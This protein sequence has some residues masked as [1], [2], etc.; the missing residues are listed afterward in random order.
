MMDANKKKETWSIDTISAEIWKVFDILKE[1]ISTEEFHVLLY[2]LSIYKDDFLHKV[3]MHNGLLK[4]TKLRMTPGIADPYEEI[5]KIYAPIYAKLTND[6]LNR[7]FDIVESIGK[8]VLVNNFHSIFDYILYKISDVLGKGDARIL[9]PMELTRLIQKIADL[10][11]EASVYNPFAG[12]ASFGVFLK[13]GQRYYGQELN[14]T[15]WAIGT[16]RILAHKRDENSIFVSGDSTENW[17]PNKEKYDLIIANPPFGIQKGYEFSTRIGKVRS[18]EA[19]FIQNGV[20]SLKDN[21]KLIAIVSQSFLNNSSNRSLITNSESLIRKYLVENDILETV[22]SF[23]GG[24]LANTAIPIAIIVINKEK[25]EKGKVRLIDAKSFIDISPNKEIKLNNNLFSCLTNNQNDK[26]N[27]RIVSNNTISQS[28]YN[29]RI[30]RYLHKEYDGIF[31]DKFVE[32]TKGIRVVEGQF[33]KF[34]RIRDLKVDEIYFNLDID[35]IE[36]AE[37]PRYAKKIAESCI[38]LAV[39]W[40]TLK[41]TFFKFSGIPIYI[42]SDIIALKIDE[43]KIDVGYFISELNKP[44]VFEQIASYRS[45]ETVPYIKPEDIL[46]I[47]IQLPS[48]SVQIEKKLLAQKEFLN[49]EEQKL[50]Q[51]RKE[52]GIDVADENSYL[53]HQIAG[54]LRNIRSSSKNIRA[55]L[56]K[57]FSEIFPDFYD[58]K[59]N[60]S[61]SLN[62][63]SYFEILE[64]D[65]KAINKSTQKTGLDIEL[66]ELNISRIEIIQFV[67][68]YYA[69]INEQKNKIYQ[70]EIDVMDDDFD[71]NI[72]TKV[73][74]NGDKELI[75][76]IFDNL[77][78]NAEK[79]AFGNN[80]SIKNWIEIILLFDFQKMEIEID[81]INNQNPVKKG[82]TIEKFIKKGMKAGKNGGDGFGLYYINEI[83]KAHGG[84]LDFCAYSSEASS[85][86][87]WVS[88]FDIKFP[89][90]IETNNYDIQGLMV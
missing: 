74:I 22:I 51:L 90:E 24:L 6:Q 40:K 12:V 30:Q 80:Y 81:F 2:L 5:N 52:T 72:E 39:R 85:G 48:L 53:R 20:D 63:R 69:E 89:I 26:E 57:Y 13:Q 1:R 31:L 66:S 82:F 59:L 83:A 64:R 76:K 71:I 84:K 55:I 61:A 38:L 9:Q 3:P 19:F 62:L 34:I 60:D 33:G 86:K 11:E 4:N 58:L 15:A 29:L 17:N 42:S 70:L 18:Y 78:E 75:R 44:Y 25:K 36:S 46:R 43:T 49:I 21:G 41:P 87:D 27:V 56:D 50:N 10:P 16:L 47:K 37:I 32:I 45:G 79:H 77:I 65:L 35:Y 8:D 73:F 68:D 67:K 14:S 88:S 28:E 54:P 7:I 23:P